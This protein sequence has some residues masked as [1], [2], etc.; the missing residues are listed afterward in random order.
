MRSEVVLSA[1]S[2]IAALSLLRRDA[3]YL[4][5]QRGIIARNGCIVKAPPQVIRIVLA[6]AG[7]PDTLVTHGELAELI[8]GDRCDGGPDNAAS[9]ICALIHRARYVFSAIGYVCRAD[10]GRI[11]ARPVL[12]E[13]EAA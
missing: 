7:R 5:Y 9:S 8:Y 3:L 11:S 10:Y 6:L 13:M 2:H 4:N 12:F 1:S